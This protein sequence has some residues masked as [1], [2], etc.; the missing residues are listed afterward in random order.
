VF[1]F[2]PPGPKIGFNPEDRFMVAIGRTLVV[3][4]SDGL[5]FGA[6]VVGRE[7][8]PVFEFTPS[9]PKI[10]FN[11]EDRFMVAGLSTDVLLGSDNLMVIR[12]DGLVFGGDVVGANV[13]SVFPFI[14][15]PEAKIGFNPEDRFMVTSFGTCG[16]VPQTSFPTA[17]HWELIDLPL[18]SDGG[19][20]ESGGK[21]PL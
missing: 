18:S 10:G 2:T 14:Q 7:I 21:F 4:R 15:G 12:S 19:G 17:A 11:P 3:I 1:E 20:P 9:G 16:L 13:Q 8:Q 5:V 6:Q